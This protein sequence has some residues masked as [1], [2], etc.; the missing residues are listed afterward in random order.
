MCLHN[1]N[2]WIIKY[3]SILTIQ[4]IYLT[5]NLIKLYYLHP[6]SN[7]LPWWSCWITMMIM[8]IPSIFICMPSDLY[9]LKI[10]NILTNTFLSL[11]LY[12]QIYDASTARYEVP[13]DIPS[14]SEKAEDTKYDILFSDNPAFNFKVVRKDTGLIMWVC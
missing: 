7:E 13:L 10:F 12:F 3:N 11:F 6:V 9:K 1:E 14:P 5:M 2:S 4:I 8:W